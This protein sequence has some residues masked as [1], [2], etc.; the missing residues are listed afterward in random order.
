MI[1]IDLGTTNSL[2]AVVNADGPVTLRDELGDDLIPSAVAV[3]EDGALLVGRA[4][5]DRLVSAPTSGRAF[6]KRD[7]GTAV[8]YAFGGKT[9]TPVECSAVVL[10]EMKRIAELHLK[11]KVGSAVITVP[12]YFH[13]LQRQAT[14]D[15]AKIAGLT[16][17]RLVNEP[18][19]AS[20]A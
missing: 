15:A 10:R 7:M 11:Q 1:G 13:D 5:K 19:A 16:V 8:S 14:M 3:A 12:A 17:E 20:L 9:W 6:F 2:V 4:A 18:T